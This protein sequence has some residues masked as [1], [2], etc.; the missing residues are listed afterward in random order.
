MTAD[1][2]VTSIDRNV[3]GAN[4]DVIEIR[5]RSKITPIIAQSQNSVIS[6]EQEGFQSSNANVVRK[7]EPSDVIMS[8]VLIKVFLS[9]KIN[10]TPCDT[11]Y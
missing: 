10:P 2:C 4:T 11:L 5:K 6:K 9:I 7:D 3:I 8:L 1:I